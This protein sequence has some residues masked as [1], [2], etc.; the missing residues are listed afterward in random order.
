MKRLFDGVGMIG[1][2]AELNEKTTKVTTQTLNYVFAAILSLY[3]KMNGLISLGSGAH[4][5]NAGTLDAHYIL[6]TFIAASTNETIPHRLNRVPVGYWVV[7]SNVIGVVFDT[8]SGSWTTE[9]ILLKA[10]AIGS[11][12]II[13]F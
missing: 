6:H 8:D 9:V 1:V 11:Y 2:P 4:G 13:V 7:R 10:S 12:V 5:S 3:R